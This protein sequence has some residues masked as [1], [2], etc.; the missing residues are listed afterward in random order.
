MLVF[1]SEMHVVTFV[2]VVLEFLM[3]IFLLAGYLNRIQDKQRRL[4]LLLLTLLLFYNITGGLLPDPK[5]PIPIFIQNIIAY[6]SGF[7]MASYFPYY[8]YKAFD[9]K[10]LRF[11]ALYG[12]PMFLLLPYLVF[13]VISYS[14]DHD[15]ASTIQHG[16]IIP[17]FYA[18][19]L[20]CAIF[21]AIRVAYKKQ[22][23][24]KYYWEE[25]LVYAAVIP[26]G[27]LSIIS[28]FD[29]GQMVEALSTNIGF[30]IVTII[31]ISKFI[32][33]DRED[34]SKLHDISVNGI[35]PELF[36]ENCIN[37]GFTT[38]QIEIVSLLHEG[39]TVREIADRLH[40]ADRTVTTHLHNMM[41]K[42]TT[43]SR[44]DLLRKLEFWVL[45]DKK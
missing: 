13:F 20:L 21:R 42:T 23:M 40:I 35:R 15:L 22:R 38:R 45:E 5:I 4:Y 8:F 12:V 39:Y 33:E 2:F 14:F 44:L 7:L 31:F 3:L 1:G 19:V 25:R 10:L 11:H 27:A 37:F 18:F 30:V 29:L 9:L 41:G 24:K 16:I 17:F 34:I 26:W 6:G 32:Q 43:H 36:Q 28:Y